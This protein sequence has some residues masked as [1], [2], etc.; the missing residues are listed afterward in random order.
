MTLTTEP[1]PDG[2]TSGGGPSV[3]DVDKN[4]GMAASVYA[5]KPYVLVS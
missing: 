5:D 3:G 2:G 4:V 1:V